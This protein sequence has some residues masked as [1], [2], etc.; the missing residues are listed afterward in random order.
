MNVFV[1]FFYESDLMR[2]NL[3]FF[4]QTT[5]PH[6]FLKVGQHHNLGHILLPNHRPEIV[7]RVLCWTLQWE[8]NENLFVH[9]QVLKS[10]V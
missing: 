4:G 6:A 9:A 8:S 7:Q 1:S 2:A 3:A 10:I 5:N